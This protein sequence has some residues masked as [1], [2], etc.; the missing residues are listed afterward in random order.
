MDDKV[1]EDTLDEN[2]VEGQEEETT[3]DGGDDEDDIQLVC[4]SS[5]EESCFEIDIQC[6]R[7]NLNV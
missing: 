4:T 6:I 7:A 2:N 3:A 5:V 1:S